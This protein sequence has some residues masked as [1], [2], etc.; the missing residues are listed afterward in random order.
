MRAPHT[1]ESVFPLEW[2]G[3]NR[4]AWDAAVSLARLSQVWDDLV[5]GDQPVPASAVNAAFLTTLA[6]LPLNPFYA[7]VQAQIAPM[8][9]PVVAAYEAANQFEKDGD[10]HGLELAHSLR[11]AA[12]HIIAYL[13]IVCV[14]QDAAKAVIPDMW[15]LIVNERF[16][17]YRKEHADAKA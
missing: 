8:W 1:H 13:I 4:A 14:G 9:L 17:D 6:Y 16:D 3:G 12:G 10:P 7:S 5:D 11:F 2:F 15:K